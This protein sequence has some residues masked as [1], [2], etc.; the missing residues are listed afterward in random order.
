MIDGAL[1]AVGQTALDYSP[2]TDA[3]GFVVRQETADE[4]GLATMSD[5]AE[6]AGDLVWGLAPGARTIPLCGRA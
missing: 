6:V 1:E 5:L 4:L 2:G 3:D